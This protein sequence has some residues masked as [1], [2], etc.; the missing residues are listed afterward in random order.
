MSYIPFPIRFLSQQEG[1]TA[2]NRRRGSQLK[3][4]RISIAILL[5]VAVPASA[6]L[7]A[8]ISGYDYTFPVGGGDFTAPNNYYEALGQIQALNGTYLASDYGNNQYTFYM[9]SDF[10]ATADTV[11]GLFGI[12]TYGPNSFIGLYE[13][14]IGSGTAYN[15]GTSPQNATAPGTFVDGAL[16]L[17]GL[18]PDLTITVNLS[19]LNG[20]LAGT[21]NWNSGSQLGGL[22]ACTTSDFA[23]LGAGD[24]GI[25]FGYVWDID[26]EINVLDCATATEEASWGE[27]KGLF[28]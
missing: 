5:F 1:L 2:A 19:T 14:P 4:L 25:P 17:G 24:P 10:I 11:A 16:I 28:R 8:D 7:L 9:L 22:G 21:I 15:Y 12:Y 20:S 13:D 23:V 18:S 27:V 26:G 3:L 6:D